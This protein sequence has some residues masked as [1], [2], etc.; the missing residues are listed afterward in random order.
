[1][2]R[3]KKAELGIPGGLALAILV[4]VVVTLTGSAVMAILIAGGTVG[5]GSGSA[6]ASCIQALSA[7]L[8]AL[9]ATACV[10]KMRLQICLL[11]GLV[12]YLVLL[13]ITALF[14]E[15]EYAGFG[16]SAL[17]VLLGCGIIAFWPSKK[18]HTGWKRR[19]SYR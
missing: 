11:S 12:Y 18:S 1:M 19:K 16:R 3:T 13:G 14:F 10:K 6:A 7:A 9:T 15:G 17:M 4:S 8:G 2:I 5:E